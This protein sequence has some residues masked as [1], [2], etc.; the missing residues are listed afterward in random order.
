MLNYY[1]N[2]QKEITKF[3]S[4][5]II[6][7]FVGDYCLEDSLLEIK[8]DTEEVNYKKIYEKNIVKIS[9]LGVS[10]KGYKKYLIRIKNSFEYDTH[11]NILIKSIKFGEGII[12]EGS[13]DVSCYKIH[14]VTVKIKLKFDQQL[15]KQLSIKIK[16]G[17]Y[18]FKMLSS[19]KNEIFKVGKSLNVFSRYN[20][21]KTINP[22]LEFIGYIM[23]EKE[24]EYSKLE[25]VLHKKFK[26]H[27][28]KREW[29]YSH[30]DIL[31]YFQTHVNFV[32][33]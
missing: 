8:I 23:I 2:N 6:K 30:K 21:A 19:N 15:I 4:D 7:S 14:T 16:S 22:D 11:E 17:V 24:K 13:G 20:N 32:E 26:E 9:S 1:D 33:I 12:F 3:I 28:Y 10:Q 29:F 25:K 31:E 27:H 18:L 5:K